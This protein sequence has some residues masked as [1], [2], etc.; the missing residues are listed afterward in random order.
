MISTFPLF[1]FNKEK[2]MFCGVCQKRPA[3]CGK[4]ITLFQGIDGSSSTGFP[5]GTLFSH[6]SRYHFFGQ[7]DFMFG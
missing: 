6:S 3:V 7:V 1:E 2:K 5:H 4:S